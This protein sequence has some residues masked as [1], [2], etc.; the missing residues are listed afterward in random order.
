MASKEWREWHLT[1]NGWV[2]GTFKHDFGLQQVSPTE[3]RLLTCVYEEYISPDANAFSGY[4]EPG[5]NEEKSINITWRCSD[6][7]RISELL[8]K[9]GSCPNHL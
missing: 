1:P 4:G 3:N 5:F 8:E 9:F 2:A 7:E 6:N